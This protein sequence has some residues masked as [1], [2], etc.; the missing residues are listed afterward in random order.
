MLTI[1]N[2]VLS[3]SSTVIE[4]VINLIISSFCAGKVVN[5][6]QPVLK[7]VLNRYKNKAPEKIVQVFTYIVDRLNKFGLVR[8]F[9]KMIVTKLIIKKTIVKDSLITTV[10]KDFLSGILLSKT[11]L[12][13]RVNTICSAISSIGGLLA[14]FISGLDKNWFD[15]Y[16]RLNIPVFRKR[17][18]CC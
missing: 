8:M 11:K 14:F 9:A 10:T 1:K 4:Y 5:A 6:A 2:G 17:F 12:L 13:K 7:Y 18:I 3:I 16:L 15:G